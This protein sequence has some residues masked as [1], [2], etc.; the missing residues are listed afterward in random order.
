MQHHYFRQKKNPVNF[1]YVLN[2][3]KLVKVD[4]IKYLGVTISN[5]LN[6]D[7]HIQSICNKGNK[8]LGILYRNL[9]FCSRDVKLA[10]YKGLFRPVLEYA[11][12]VWDPHQSYLQDK[13]ESIQRRSA[14]FVSSEFAREPGSS[15]D[16]IYFEG[17]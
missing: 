16:D 9:S 6:W 11:Y 12:C 14:C 7:K 4:S 17:P 13:L 15:V 1:D 5:D 3:V 2:D 10:A 8:I